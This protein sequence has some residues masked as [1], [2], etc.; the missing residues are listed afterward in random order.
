VL[1]SKST[2]AAKAKE[3]SD[4]KKKDAA[5]EFALEAAK[6]AAHTRC[7]NVVVLNVR[8][9]SPICDFF[10]LASGTSAR[11]MRSVADEIVELGEKMNSKSIHTDGYDG[12]SWIL[13][14]FVDVVV[15]LFSDEARSYY[16]LDNLWGDADRI[17]IPKG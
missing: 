14:D 11:Q 16:D 6:L 3:K 10:V 4:E 15:H 8:G 12:E 9:L 5:R 1:I 2:E 17:E 13:V 7:H